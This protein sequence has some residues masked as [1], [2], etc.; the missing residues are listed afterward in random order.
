MFTGIPYTINFTD[1]SLPGKTKFRVVPNSTDGP[2]TPTSNTP[3]TSATEIHTSLIIPGMGLV[4]YGERIGE[5]LVHLLENFAGYLPPVNPTIGQEWFDF[6]TKDMKVWDGDT[7]QSVGGGGIV[8][9]VYEYNFLVT[10]INSVI[11]TTSSG[12]VEDGYVD[13]SYVL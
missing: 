4:Q 12:Y 11:G 6:N 1:P 13:D 10:L 9:S 3:D 8:A 7:W 2:L 5:D